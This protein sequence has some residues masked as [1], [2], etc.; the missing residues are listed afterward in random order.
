LTIFAALVLAVPGAAQERRHIPTDV[1][2]YGEPA[3][4]ADRSAIDA[5]IRQYRDAWSRQD[6][7]AWVSLHSDDTE[8]INAYARMFQGSAPLAEFIEHKLFP[9]FDPSVSKREAANM[10]M[11]SIRYMGDD[12]AVVHMY[13]ESPRGPSR[14]EGEDLRRTH[15]HLVLSES[16]EE[17][18]IVHTAI[19]DAR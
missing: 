12:A 10:R 15:F 11:I 1:R 5:L 19:M 8:W 17:W 14:T 6:T 16:G 3:S 4:A 7:Q 13:T 2:T 9:E 18:R